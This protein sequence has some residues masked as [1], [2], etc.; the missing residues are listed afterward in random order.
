MIGFITLTGDGGV[1]AHVQPRHICAMLPNHDSD[2]KTGLLIGSTIIL[3]RET[4]AEIFDLC[5]R[6]G[7]T[8]CR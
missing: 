1:P 7:I 8:I 5:M 2:G 3:I 4:P 6:A